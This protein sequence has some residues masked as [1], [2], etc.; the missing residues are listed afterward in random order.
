MKISQMIAVL[1]QRLNIEGDIQVGINIGK[2]FK[3]VA[4]SLTITSQPDEDGN[5]QKFVIFSDTPADQVKESLGATEE[6]K[7]PAKRKGSRK[8]GA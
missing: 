8:K 2:E 3:H 1:A 7:A 5:V 6:K 4:N